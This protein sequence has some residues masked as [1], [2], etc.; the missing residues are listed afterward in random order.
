MLLELI[1]L[2]VQGAILTRQPNTVDV[3]TYQQ[4]LH[5]LPNGS[6]DPF[7]PD[8][9][10]VRQTTHFHL[11]A[12]SDAVQPDQNGTRSFLIPGMKFEGH[13]WYEETGKSPKALA[14]SFKLISSPFNRADFKKHRTSWGN[15]DDQVQPIYKGNHGVAYECTTTTD[16]VETHRIGTKRV[17]RTK[18]RDSWSLCVNLV[19]EGQF[20]DPARCV[21]VDK[22]HVCVDP[23][24][25]GY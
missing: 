18:H 10:F 20:Y 19:S 23:P 1:C 8:N 2:Q 25:Y 24:V 13:E 3:V 17:T 15:S 6:P 7:S 21:Y 11:L 5:S 9:F 16:E 4:V 22:T 12:D 14:A